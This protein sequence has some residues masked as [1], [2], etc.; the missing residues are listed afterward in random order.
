MARQLG[1]RI[2]FTTSP[3][4]PLMFNWVPLSDYED[5]RRPSWHP[6]GQ[7]NDPLL[8]LPRYWNK[9]AIDHLD[10][11]IQI[12]EE[13]AAY[14]EQNKATELLYYDIVCAPTYGPIP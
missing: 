5:P 10:K 7:M 8:L 2:G 14:A 12:S 3:R 4:G 9:D 11:V 6:E 1:Y 13:A